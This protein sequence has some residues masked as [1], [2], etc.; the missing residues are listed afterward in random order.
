[1]YEILLPARRG[2][3]RVGRQA[4]PIALDLVIRRLN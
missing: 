2:M 1:V 4:V 3:L